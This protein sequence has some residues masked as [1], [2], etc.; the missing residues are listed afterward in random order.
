MN[1][2]KEMFKDSAKELKSVQTLATA[3]MLTA[4]TAILGFFTIVIGDFIKIQFSFLPMG[5]AGM[6]FGPVVS[7][8][9]GGISDIICFIIKPTG[10]FFP[11]FTFNAIIS[12]LI[13]GIFLYKKPISLK[14]IFSA[15]LLIT[16]I[17]ELCLTTTW[18]NILYGQGFL[19]ILPMRIVKCAVMLPIDTVMLYVVTSR[20][21]SILHIGKKAQQ[22]G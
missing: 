16:L 12:G 20:L 19:A 6:M 2:I 7:G 4:I 8:I 1:K 10:T 5:I 17:V 3:A 14:R 13:Y 18:L 9:L 11:G 15:K 21:G 22:T